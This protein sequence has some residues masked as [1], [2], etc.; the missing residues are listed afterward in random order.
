MHENQE[1][2]GKRANDGHGRAAPAL[3]PAVRTRRKV[4]VGVKRRGGGGEGRG[5]NCLLN[6]QQR[7]EDEKKGKKNPESSCN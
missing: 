1:Q 6:R 5:V 2:R 4:S 7:N 3:P